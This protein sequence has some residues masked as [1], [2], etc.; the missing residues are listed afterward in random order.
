MIQ[1]DHSIYIPK[2]TESRVPKRCIHTPVYNSTVHSSREVEADHI[3]SIEV[4]INKMRY[5][6]GGISLSLKKER[7]PVTCY[8]TWMNFEDTM[9]GEIISH[10]QTDKYCVIPYELS[11]IVKFIEREGRTVFGGKITEFH[12]YKVKKF[13][14][15]IAQQWKY[16]SCCW[17]VHLKMVKKHWDGVTGAE[18][19]QR[20]YSLAGS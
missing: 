20:Y 8:T 4:W 13:W 15:S 12:F 9:L 17:A 7:S 5:P 6:Y 19:R 1:Q 10:S 3:S 11:R 18:F 14:R 2:W 16:P